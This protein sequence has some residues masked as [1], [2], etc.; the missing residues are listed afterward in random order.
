M[1]SYREV[2]DFESSPRVRVGVMDVDHSLESDDD[3]T[4]FSEGQMSR[5]VTLDSSEIDGGCLLQRA[6][7]RCRDGGERDPPIIRVGESLNKAG[8]LEL[9]DDSADA[10]P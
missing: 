4:L 10:G 6:P 7:T 3:G 2:D 9:G 5:E 8:L 1:P